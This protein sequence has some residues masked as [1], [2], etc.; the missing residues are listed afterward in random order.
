MNRLTGAHFSDSAYDPKFPAGNFAKHVT[1]YD[2]KGN[3]LGLSVVTV[4]RAR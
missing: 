3:I 2:K 4:K 1:A